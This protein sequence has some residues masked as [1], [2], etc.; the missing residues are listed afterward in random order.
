MVLSKICPPH[1]YYI[2]ERYPKRKLPNTRDKYVIYKDDA[3]REFLGEKIN[4]YDTHDFQNKNEYF[5]MTGECQKCGEHETFQFFDKMGKADGLIDK[6][7]RDAYEL[8]TEHY[9]KQGIWI[10]DGYD[11]ETSTYLE[12]YH[13]ETGILTDLNSDI[14]ADK[15][16]PQTIDYPGDSDEILDIFENKT[17]IRF[18]LREKFINNPHIPLS[19]VEKYLHLWDDFILFGPPLE[20]NKIYL[21][22]KNI[23]DNEIFSLVREI[24]RNAIPDKDQPTLEISHSGGIDLTP[25][26]AV[27]FMRGEMDKIIPYF[28]PGKTWLDEDDEKPK[29]YDHKLLQWCANEP[30]QKL[31]I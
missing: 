9:P 7:A 14:E 25:Y 11:G 13:R 31:S 27:R 22:N 1:F 28:I 30:V 18:E 6:F 5:H 15:E 16:D 12:N 24:L 21:D 20:W 8:S 3:G 17:Y 4:N 29:K 19:A 23:L 2:S 10:K 26:N